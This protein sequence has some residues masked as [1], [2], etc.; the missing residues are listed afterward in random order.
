MS[1][2]ATVNVVNDE[3]MSLQGSVN[4]PV[5][6]QRSTTPDQIMAQAPTEI[7]GIPA[8]LLVGTQMSRMSGPSGVLEQTVP[9]ASMQVVATPTVVVDAPSCAK[10]K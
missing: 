3:E 10:T 6:P 4:A 8:T 9:V 7:V 2:Q 5:A 1:H